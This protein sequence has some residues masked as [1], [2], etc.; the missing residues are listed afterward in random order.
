MPPSS[1]YKNLS[2][3]NDND[4]FPTPSSSSPSPSL[5]L[6]DGS[7][8]P[9]A[10]SYILDSSAMGT[11]IMSG[12]FLGTALLSLGETATLCFQLSAL[13]NNFSYSFEYLRNILQHNRRS[14]S[15]ILQLPNACFLH[16]RSNGHNLRSRLCLPPSSNRRFS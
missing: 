6:D 1:T 7:L 9:L 12:L 3:D 14:R 13:S 10:G 11:N 5:E 4:P 15:K 16:P 8:P 2:L